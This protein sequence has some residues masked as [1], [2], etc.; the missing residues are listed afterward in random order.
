MSLKAEPTYPF[1]LVNG[2]NRGGL[3][4]DRSS[5]GKVRQPDMRFLRAED[6]PIIRL[7]PSLTHVGAAQ[8]IWPPTRYFQSEE[9]QKSESKSA[10]ARVL[11]GSVNERGQKERAN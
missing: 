11:R 2:K 10:Q 1:P 4:Q 3:V 7:N 5:G 6:R 8:R 9:V